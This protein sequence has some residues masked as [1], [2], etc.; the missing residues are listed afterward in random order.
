MLFIDDPEEAYQTLRKVMMEYL[1]MEEE[2]AGSDHGE[3]SDH[4][5]HGESDCDL[6]TLLIFRRDN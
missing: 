5:P 3:T 2:P 6:F 4:T 1:G